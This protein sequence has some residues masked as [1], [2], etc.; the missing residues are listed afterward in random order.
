MFLEF[1]KQELHRSL[2]RMQTV[3]VLRGARSSQ[4][5]LRIRLAIWPLMMFLKLSHIMTI[6][7]LKRNNTEVKTTGL[8]YFVTN[9]RQQII[10]YVIVSYL[11]MI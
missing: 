10:V 2:I 11:A 5:R 4:K 7:F 6:I 9:S 3:F 1:F 8:R